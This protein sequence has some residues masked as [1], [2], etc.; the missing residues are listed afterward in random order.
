MEV[1]K[2][3]PADLFKEKLANAMKWLREGLPIEMDK[4][5]YVSGVLMGSAIEHHEELKKIEDGLLK[6]PPVILA[7]LCR[8]HLADFL[9][10]SEESKKGTT[11]KR[12]HTQ[13]FISNML[14]NLAGAPFFPPTLGEA[15]AA[16]T[17]ELP[18]LDGGQLD[19]LRRYLSL[20][21][22]LSMCILQEVQSKAAVEEG[23]EK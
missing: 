11:A 17:E 15:V 14:R 21:A 7:V 23:E 4:D 9:P 6:S 22:E 18:H 1:A 19:K 20:F 2:V 10:Q 16:V 3:L 8:H 5:Y 13:K 12:E